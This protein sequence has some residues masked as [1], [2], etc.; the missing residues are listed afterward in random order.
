[1]NTKI[2][3]VVVVAVFLVFPIKAVGEWFFIPETVF[4][5]PHRSRAVVTET[6]ALPA[7]MP[8]GR[9]HCSD[10]GKLGYMGLYPRVFQNI[11]PSDAISWAKQQVAESCEDS[12]TSSSCKEAL[13][14]LALVRKSVHIC[15]SSSAS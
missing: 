15:A 6:R 9:L 11:A 5:A 3:Q 1:M 12:W 7:S 4:H 8:Q 13:H 10:S 14:A 2:L